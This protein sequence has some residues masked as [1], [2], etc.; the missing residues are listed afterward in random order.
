MGKLFF[1]KLRVWECESVNAES[2]R[3]LWGLGAA[4]EGCGVRSKEM[5][6]LKIIKRCYSIFFNWPVQF[7]LVFSVLGLLNWNRTKLKI[8]K[9]IRIGL[10]SFFLRFDFF[11]YF[12]LFSQFNRFFGF[13]HSYRQI[14]YN[15]VF[16][17]WPK[18]V[19]FYLFQPL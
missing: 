15:K 7:G 19:M 5:L 3:D 9:K 4:C 10:I 14:N 13:L 1:I 12:F 16:T 18:I 6:G 8:F 11:D 2:V 17:S